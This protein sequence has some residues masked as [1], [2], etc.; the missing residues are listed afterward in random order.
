MGQHNDPELLLSWDGGSTW[1]TGKF[2]DPALAPK[3]AWILP[4]PIAKGVEPT[5][6]FK[7]IFAAGL[8]QRSTRTRLLDD[9]W[10]GFL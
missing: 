4:Q 1:Q 5:G 3:L 9:R 8:D 2:D 7:G 6:S 10:V